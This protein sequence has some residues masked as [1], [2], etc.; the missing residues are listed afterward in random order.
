MI[1]RPCVAEGKPI[2][3][4]PR[5]IGVTET[6]FRDAQQSIMA[7]RLSTEDMLP[8]VEAMD[9]VGYQSVEV[10]GGATFDA[11]MRFL[12]EDPWERLRLL[13]Q[14]FKKT[15]LQMLVRGQNLVGYRHYADD[16]VREFIKR[17]VG[18]GIDIIRAF[19]ALNDLR[20]LEVVAD[21]TKREGV[22]LQLALCYTLSPVHTLDSFVELA[23]KMEEMGSDS[24]CIKDMAGL[25]DPI[26]VA[27]LVRAIRAKSTLP[28]Q[29]HSHFTSGMAAMVYF[30]AI[31]SGADAVDCAISPFSMGSSHPPTE[32]LVAALKEGE[33]YD[34]GIELK[35]LLPV[36]SYFRELR[37]RYHDT[38]TGLCGMD[39][40]V[41][42]YQIPGGMYSNLVRQL[43]EAGAE[44]RLEEVLS[45]VPRVRMEMGYPPL[46]TPTSQMVGTQATLNVI[47]RKRWSLIPE[48]VKRYFL[49]YYGTP[50]GRV[51]ET[52]RKKAIGDASPIL[53]RPGELLSPELKQAQ[54]EIGPWA[55][56]PEDV[57]SYVLFPSV[58][59]EF[60]KKKFARETLR[61][62]GVGNLIEGFAYPV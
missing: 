52:I 14:R 16:V 36:V 43:K 18:N 50:P 31:E 4:F 6:A 10:W 58:A 47:T 29:I 7:T 8:I 53:S 24:I 30:A 23:T 17:S 34:T 20:N 57:L 44:D 12:N 15:P 1:G 9:L 45:E 60:L 56:D 11:C 21:Q 48:E 19:D 49:G 54:K 35:N 42:I 62:P 5:K 39:I 40:N 61:N 46:V 2:K 3:A 55:L 27:H 41:L 59:L 38:I 13:R 28:I 26:T 22:H 33:E 51:D 37:N 25:L 32:S